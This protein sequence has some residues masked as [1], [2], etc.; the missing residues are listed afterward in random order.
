MFLTCNICKHSVEYPVSE[1]APGDDLFKCRK[2]IP[3]I[4]TP[5]RNQTSEF[6]IVEGEW[7][8]NKYQKAMGT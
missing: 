6:P 4:P 5:D 7:E 3:V 8:C 2:E 1:G